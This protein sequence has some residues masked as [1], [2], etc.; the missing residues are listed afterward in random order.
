MTLSPSLRAR[1]RDAAETV[2][3]CVTALGLI[4]G[5]AGVFAW[6][7]A[8]VTAMGPWPS[9]ADRWTGM[10]IRGL[11][12][13]YVGAGFVALLLAVRALNLVFRAVAGG[14]PSDEAA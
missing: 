11:L 10:E 4:L 8:S 6:A 5:M 14:R 12:L 7:D 9:P 3:V 2:V 1:I 13:L